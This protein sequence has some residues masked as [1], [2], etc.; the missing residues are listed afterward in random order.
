MIEVTLKVIPFGYGPWERKI[1]MFEIKNIY[2]RR[3]RSNVQIA[4]YEVSVYKSSY[5]ELPLDKNNR[6]RSSSL[7]GKFIVKS[8]P[9]EKGTIEEL[10]K[11]ALSS[12]LRRNKSLD[13][14]QKNE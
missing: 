3:N 4:D 13:E 10:V 2:T 1:V 9:R 7:K 14:R 8:F 11:R 6:P 5:G 12:Y